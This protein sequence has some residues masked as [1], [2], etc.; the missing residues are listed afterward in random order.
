MRLAQG[1]VTA[2]R[3]AVERL[4]QEAHGPQQRARLLPTAVEI[5]LL[6]GDVEAARSAAEGLHAAAEQIGG[7]YVDALADTAIGTVL[8]AE[9]ASMEALG[10]LR[11]AADLW[12][13]LDVPYEVAR[14][15]ASIGLA[16]RALGDEDT[17]RLELDAAR[18]G[19]E[20][21]GAAPDLERVEKL[22]DRPP[23]ERAEGLTGREVEVLA[24][25]ATGKT[26]RDIA[27]QLFISEKTVARHVS[28]IFVKI[29]VS[30][31]A[32]A[33]AYA[34]QHELV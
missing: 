28:N 3:A 1:D 4:L 29:G 7:P 23:P 2:A 25:V 12:R 5:A 32:A 33:T 18:W 21:L 13:Q 14:V 6:A 16:C 20:Q 19:F 17:A 24:L 22:L 8:L 15:R 10:E 34:Y 30:S 26:N 11:P 27:G 31:R 9:G